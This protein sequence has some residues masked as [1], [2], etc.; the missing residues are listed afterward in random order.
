MLVADGDVPPKLANTLT[1]A[2]GAAARQNEIELAERMSRQ[3][4]ELR[5]QRQ[6]PAGATYENNLEVTQ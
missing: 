3:A 4:E 5:T 2:I 6:L 1:F